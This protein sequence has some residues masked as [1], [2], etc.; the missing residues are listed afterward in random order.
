M[1]EDQLT[2]IDFVFTTYSLF[3]EMWVVTKEGL[4]YCFVSFF[5]D[6][7]QH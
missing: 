1:K 4:G 3:S 5:Y 2:E 6:R 7:R